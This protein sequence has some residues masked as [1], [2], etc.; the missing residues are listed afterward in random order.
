MKGLS[1]MWNLMTELDDNVFINN[2]HC[3]V[4][5]FSMSFHIYYIDSRCL[6]MTFDKES[7]EEEIKSRL[8]HFVNRDLKEKGWVKESNIHLTMESMTS[9]E[10]I[11]LEIEGLEPKTIHQLEKEHIDW[12]KKQSEYN[13]TNDPYYEQELLYVPNEINCVS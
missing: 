13:P 4:D 7:T 12:V 3:S 6:R 5:E 11:N 10:I 1:N 8:L 9:N 2:W